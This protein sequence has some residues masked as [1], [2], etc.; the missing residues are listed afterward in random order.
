MWSNE[1]KDVKSFLELFLEEGSDFLPKEKLSVLFETILPF[2]GKKPKNPECK[3]KL[4]SLALLA[5]IATTNFVNQKNYY[6][7]IET[8]TL[9]IAYLLAFVE[10]WNLNQKLWRDEFDLALSII[11]DN[12]TLLYKEIKE[13]KHLVEGN[14]WGD[15]LFYYERITL[16]SSLLSIYYLWRRYD[17]I[18]VDEIDKF[19]VQFLNNNIRKMR[20]WGEGAIP[21][22][23]VTYFAYKKKYAGVI[24]DSFIKDLI[25]VICKYNR[26]ESKC[27]LFDPYR[28]LPV[29][30]FSRFIGIIFKRNLVQITIN[31]LCL[32]SKFHLG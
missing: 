6:A 18:E 22:F 26:I 20:L 16:L 3:R 31:K 23:I 5:S 19:I 24:P 4:S 28:H 9:Y 11:Y 17:N 13:R 29:F 27:P 15:Y 25:Q 10:R 7:Q 12:L 8:W 2:S 21:Q 14:I 32:L 1:T 30:D